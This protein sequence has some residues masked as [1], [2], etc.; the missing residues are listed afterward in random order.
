[1]DDRPLRPL[2]PRKAKNPQKMRVF[3][4][5]RSGEDRTAI[6]LFIAGVWMWEV[7]LR[8]HFLTQEML[9]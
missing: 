7:D 9:P 2:D 8:R 4:G 6:E 1:M 3:L 5:K